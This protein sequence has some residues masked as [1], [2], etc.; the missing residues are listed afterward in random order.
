MRAT[1]NAQTFQP[2]DPSE[3][4][5]DTA[6]T[7]LQP[8]PKKNKCGVFGRIFIAIIAIAVTAL[9]RLPALKLAAGL[10]GKGAA[11][12][13]VAGAA[14]A[15]AGSIVSQGVAVATGIH[16]KFS[17]NAVGLAA[18]GGGV[19][20][21]GVGNIAAKSIGFTGNAIG[22][23]GASLNSALTQGIGVATGL[24]DKFDWAGVAAAGAGAYVGAKVGGLLPTNTPPFAANLVA[25][26][27]SALANAATRSLID[28]SDFGDNILAALPDVLGQTIGGAFADGISGASK[29]KPL[30]ASKIE[31]FAPMEEETDAPIPELADLPN[32]PSLAGAANTTGK[33]QAT[34]LDES[35]LQEAQ[36]L[37]DIPTLDPLAPLRRLA[38]GAKDE[39]LRRLGALINGALREATPDAR[40]VHGANAP[41]PLDINTILSPEA[42]ALVEQSPSLMNA[43]ITWDRDRWRIQLDNS[44]TTDMRGHVIYLD[45]SALRN[46][47]EAV[48]AL[49]HEVGH[50]MSAVIADTSS[51]A[52][53]VRSHLA[54]EGDATIMGIQ[55][56]REIRAASG[57][58][59]GLGTANDAAYNSIY[60]RYLRDGDAAR[61][62]GAIGAIYENGEIVG[63]SS[64]QTYG[65]YFRAYYN[66]M[67]G[68]A[69]P[70]PPQPPSNGPNGP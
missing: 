51:Q 57:V 49:S 62:R 38:D 5:G 39:V 34:L 42:R 37:P 30:T 60:D 48:R 44:S 31:L 19:G 28:G 59:I 26:T 50:A 23:V 68:T 22:A 58:D 16:D 64:G 65:S 36:F 70:T 17:W 56:Q 8:T 32:M 54:M 35:L 3:T 61:A 11:A 6:P 69:R 4:I 9:T 53:Y 33:F 55:V 45:R 63:F 12:T 10:I 14:S 24:Q 7:T 67:Y 20:A 15:A 13:V 2:Y 21:S 18:I 52:A 25:S 40:S 66:Y 46:P 27:A 43:L 29:Q 47:A 41:S 1:H